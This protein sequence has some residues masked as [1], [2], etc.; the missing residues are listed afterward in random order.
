MALF[1]GRLQNILVSKWFAV[2][3]I[4]LLLSCLSIFPIANASAQ[5]CGW[6]WDILSISGIKTNYQSGETISGNISFR[7]HNAANSKAT[8]QLLVGIIDLQN[9]VIDVNCVYNGV[10]KECPAWTTGTA[11]FSLKTPVTP[12]NYKVIAADDLVTSCSHAINRFPSLCSPKSPYCKDITTITI[13]APPPTPTKEDSTTSST[14]GGTTQDGGASK[15]GVSTQFIIV[16]IALLV[17]LFIFSLMGSKARKRFIRYILVLAVVSFL[18]YLFWIYGIPAITNWF[19]Q[20]LPTIRNVLLALVALAVVGVLWKYKDEI[21]EKL[22][23]LQGENDGGNQGDDRKTAKGWI[24]IL[25]CP[26]NPQD[27][28]KI[29]QTQLT[30]EERAAQISRDTGVAVPFLV[31]RSWQVS[32]CQKAESLIHKALGTYRTSPKKEFFVGPYRVFHATMD[33]IAGEINEGQ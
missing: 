26:A 14:G 10:P 3:L 25:H 22:K 30:P 15:K 1:V 20:N 19:R 2:V 12:G 8:Q 29:G 4:S 18:G 31:V 32:D 11:S 33:R 5:T 6:N 28:F 13:S 23:E 16:A 27:W 21:I 17:L 9:R 7:L 24:Y